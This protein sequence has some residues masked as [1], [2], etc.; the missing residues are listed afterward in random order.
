MEYSNTKVLEYVVHD[1]HKKHE[2]YIEN[3][4]QVS[5]TSAVRVGCVYW[6]LANPWDRLGEP[7]WFP[8]T[9]LRSTRFGRTII[10]QNIYYRRQSFCAPLHDDDQL[11]ATA[12]ES[13]TSKA[14]PGTTPEQAASTT[15]KSPVQTTAE[16]AATTPGTPPTCKWNCSCYVTCE[17][18]T[19]L[20][21]GNRYLY[22]WRA[23]CRHRT[24]I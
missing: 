16:T 6:P 21:E 12:T 10:R 4:L 14:A 23:C 5:V 20:S 17:D 22:I 15:S 24:S 7:M 1:V 18:Q 3:S 9:Q 2:D 11:Y 19:V 8:V 13:T